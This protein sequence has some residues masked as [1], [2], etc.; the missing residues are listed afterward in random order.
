MTSN[1]D[2]AVK[3]LL[4]YRYPIKKLA[5]KPIYDIN[6]L[7]R[8]KKILKEDFNLFLNRYEHLLHD[9]V[10]FAEKGLFTPGPKQFDILNVLSNAYN[11]KSV[12]VARMW[13]IEAMNLLESDRYQEKNA[14]SDIMKWRFSL[15]NF[16]LDLVD[17]AFTETTA[18]NNKLHNY[19]FKGTEFDEDEDDNDEDVEENI[20]KFY[21]HFKDS[22]PEESSAEEETDSGSISDI[23]PTATLF[24][25]GLDFFG[26][27]PLDTKNDQSMPKG[28]CKLREQNDKCIKSQQ[29][30]K[31]A[32]LK[33]TAVRKISK[34]VEGT[35]K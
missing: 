18:F 11:M 20:K 32:K 34:T 27:K 15:D 8:M 5:P 9:N 4:S 6:H 22:T 33:L 35:Q 25:I 29:T 1:E 7:L 12:H 3:I 19:L 21:S 17:E 2:T 24:D 23:E 14:F 16:E 28:D 26:I 13:A 31:R 10:P 30:W